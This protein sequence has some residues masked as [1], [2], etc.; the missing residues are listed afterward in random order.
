MELMNIDVIAIEVTKKNFSAGEIVFF[1]I[2]DFI[3]KYTFN[4]RGVSS[5]DTRQ[6]KGC[7]GQCQ[8]AA[9]SANFQAT[10]R[11]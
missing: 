4:R 10:Q 11:Y 9:G 2:G 7:G 3:G 8:Q 6:R 1:V 5:S